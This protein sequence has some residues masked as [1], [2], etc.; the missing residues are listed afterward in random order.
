MTQFKATELKLLSVSLLILQAWLLMR[1][2]ELFC[3]V[4]T[5]VLSVLPF[6]T[7]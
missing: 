4:G 1:Y 6:N 7:S 2:L 3:M 5:G